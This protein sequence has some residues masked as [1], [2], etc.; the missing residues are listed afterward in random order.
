M[1][2]IF[3]VANGLLFCSMQNSRTPVSLLLQ[4]TYRPSPP[5]LG[6]G[7]PCKIDQPLCLCLR[8]PWTVPLDL[9]GY[10]C[11]IDKPFC[12]CLRNPCIV[13]SPKLLPDPPSRLDY[14]KIYRKIRF[15]PGVNSFSC[16]FCR[17][18]AVVVVR[19]C[20]GKLGWPAIVPLIVPLINDTIT[21]IVP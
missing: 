3:H 5:S 4:N 21:V 9:C 20:L 7:Y 6:C 1:L 15:P 11:K 17:G 19:P 2:L 10:P 12:L 13:P 16:I 14:D 8:N 18:Q